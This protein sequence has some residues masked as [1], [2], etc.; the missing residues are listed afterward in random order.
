MLDEK[1]GKVA[2]DERK[3]KKRKKKK[4]KEKKREEKCS[5]VFIV[6]KILC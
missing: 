6:L 3:K 1:M 5:I 4:R 2:K